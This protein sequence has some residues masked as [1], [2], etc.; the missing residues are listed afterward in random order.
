MPERGRAAPGRGQR[1]AGQRARAQQRAFRDQRDHR[2]PGHQ[3]DTRIGQD[4]LRE[5]VVDEHEVVVGRVVRGVVAAGR[6]DLG[7]GVEDGRGELGEAPHRAAGGQVR[8]QPA[9]RRPPAPG[10]AAAGRGQLQRVPEHGR[11]PGELVQGGPRALREQEEHGAQGGQDQVAGQG[12]QR[13]PQRQV[14]QQRQQRVVPV[15]PA[16]PRGRRRR[17]PVPGRGLKVVDDRVGDH[18]DPVPGRVHPPAEVDVVAQQRHGRVEAADLVP[19]IPADQHPGAAHGHHVAIAVVLALVHLAGLHAGDPPPGAVD[20]DTGLEQYPLVGPVHDLGAE[21]RRRARLSRPAQELLQGVRGGLAVVVQQPDP[22]GPVA[23]RQPG[24]PRDVGVGRPVPQRVRDGRAVA[25]PAVHAEHHRA[26][27]QLGEH[28]PAAVPAAGV[29]RHDPLHR[30]GLAEQRLGD[31]RQPRGAIVSDDHRGNDVLALR[32]SCQ[33]ESACW[34][35]W[36]PAGAPPAVRSR[37]QPGGY[38]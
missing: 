3:Q 29:D 8:P 20:R 4:P 10:P 22:L 34:S 7:R 23:G 9:V 33:H 5:P 15:H 13:G 16:R 38:A 35:E 14:G 11:H 26:A 24:R 36:S 30:P 27:Q 19:D 32:V 1:P 12:G 2:E 18:P 21:H 28:G 31:T 6:V 25:G 17:A 37:S